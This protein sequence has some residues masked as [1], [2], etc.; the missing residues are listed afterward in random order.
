MKLVSAWK[1]VSATEKLNFCFI[2]I[3][4]NLSHHRWMVATVWAVA[5]ASGS[6]L[7]AFPPPFF[8]VSSPCSP[9]A[10]F[11]LLPS[12]SLTEPHSNSGVTGTH[13]LLTV[14]KKQ[15]WCLWK[16]D[17]SKK[18]CFSVCSAFFLLV[19]WSSL[20]IGVKPRSPIISFFTYFL[21]L[22]SQGRT[23][24]F[25]VSFM[26]T[27]SWSIFIKKLPPLGFEYWMGPL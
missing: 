12:V 26:I 2:L 20:H 19:G 11:F 15:H 14:E 24:L 21:Y 18:N 13:L 5:T 7:S 27:V 1:V 22:L 25:P 16:W 8:W 3:Y 4:L 10:E 6:R 9:R 17:R 23:V